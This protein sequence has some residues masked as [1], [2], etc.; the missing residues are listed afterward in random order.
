MA[1]RVLALNFDATNN[2]KVSLG[3]LA[4]NSSLSA[5]GGQLNAPQAFFGANNPANKA[6]LFNGSYSAL[7][8]VAFKT[9][10]FSIGAT[11]VNAYT[12][13][14]IFDTGSG[15]AVV[16]TSAGNFAF[17]NAAGNKRGQF[18]ST[19]LNA[20]GLSGSI[21]LGKTI[22]VNAFGTYIE[23]NKPG[24]GVGRGEIWTYGAGLGIADFGKKGNLLGLTAGVEPYLGNSRK[25]RQGQNTQPIH[26]EAFYRY[27]LSDNISITPGVI[28]VINP[29]QSNNNDDIF[30]GTLRTTFTF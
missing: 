28:Y 2:I 6:G 21:N 20:Y 27:Q 30:I 1:V 9:D 4:N 7:A 25:F 26:F 23:A 12:R 11:Y 22:S 16:G 14:A 19:S 29:G 10:F 24:D 13:G 3:Y 17:V 15:G 8:Q 5:T 18:T